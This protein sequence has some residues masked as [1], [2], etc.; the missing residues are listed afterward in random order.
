MTSEQTGKVQAAANRVMELQEELEAS[1]FAAIDETALERSR[2]ALHKWIDS[3]TGVVISPA[4][5]RVT[6]I[7]ENGRESSI[8]SAELPFILSEPVGNR[9]DA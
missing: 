4:L 8:S 3:V 2:A 5:G 6:L 7:H 9:S 1:G